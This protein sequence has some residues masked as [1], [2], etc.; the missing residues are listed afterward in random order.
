MN[1]DSFSLKCGH[2]AK[3]QARE[4]EPSQAQEGRLPYVSGQFSLLVGWG[5]NTN[6]SFGK[7]LV[8]MAQFLLA[9]VPESAEESP[10]AAL[11][12]SPAL[13]H[14]HKVYSY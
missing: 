4:N 13:L 3:L 8:K 9:G 14:V 10:T 11:S 1:L 6:V 2:V 7:Y 5:V 12:T